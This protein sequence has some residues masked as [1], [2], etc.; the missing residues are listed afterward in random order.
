MNPQTFGRY[1][2]KEQLGR[3]GFAS[4][5][6]AYD[7]RFK[8]DV[9]VKVLPR[10]LLLDDPQFR[11][12]FEREAETIAALE[13]PAI[14][15]V[16]DF[17]EENGQPYLVM[18]LMA[19]G[20]LA[21]RITQGPLPTAEAAHILRRIGSAL[22]R[23]HERGVIHRD[24]KPGNIL[25]DQYGEAFLAD[26]GIVRL[27][28]AGGT[29][30]ATGG[31]VGTPA[32]MSPEQIR[33]SQLD[34]R[35]DIYALGIIVFE[36]LTG[37]KP[38]DADTPAMM[39]VKQIT[40]P[41]PRVLSVNPDLPPGCEYVITR[42][43]AKEAADRFDKAGEMADT[44]ASALQ[45]QTFDLPPTQAA[46]TQVTAPTQVVAPL[47]VVDPTVV[48]PTPPPP[49]PT[50]TTAHRPPLWVW[51]IAAAALI[52]VCACGLLALI[53]TR[54]APVLPGGQTTA[55]AAETTTA[56]DTAVS[57]PIT[58]DNITQM[59]PLQRL[60]RGTLYAA[61]L[62][63]D[64]NRLALGSSVGVWIYDAHSLEP[65]QLLEGH[66]DRVTAV[67][68]SPDGRQVASASW[69]STIRL[70]DIDSGEQVRMIQGND[71]FIALDWSP[72][73]SLLA[74]TTWGSPV[75]LYDPASTQKMGELLGNEGSVTRLAWSPDGAQLAAAD[76]G[77]NATVRLWDVTARVETAP[78]LTGHT[79]E[80]ANL[81][82]ASDSARLISS[83]FDGTAR[84]WSVDGSE[85]FVLQGHEY[86]VYDAAWSP[87]ETQILTTGGDNSVR[88]WDAA[89]GGQIRALPSPLSPAIRLIWL[90]ATNQIITFLADGTIWQ[91]DAATDAVVKENY[92]HTAGVW[93]VAWS[94]DGQLLASGG[95]DG[96]VRLWQPATG[97]QLAM[98]DA[99]DYGVSAIAFSADGALLASA[100]GDGFLR[101]WEV[102]QELEIKEWADPDYGGFSALAFAPHAPWL[103]A[104]DWD[105][106]VWLLDAADLTVLADWQ[107]FAEAPV[108]DV[109]WSPDGAM[110][111]I[112]GRDTAVPLWT[113]TDNTPTLFTEL[114]GHG[115]IVTDVTWSPDGAQAATSSQ[116]G[117]VRVWQV[118]ESQEVWQQDL[119]DLAMSAAW[120]SAG[121]PLAAARYDG[122]LFLVD[123]VNG[124]ELRQLSGHVGSV[125]SMVWSPDGAWLA[126][127]SSDGTVIVWGVGP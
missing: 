108:T 68:W 2:I 9:A 41:M 16:Y 71:Q 125:E 120:S 93:R 6:R 61:I 113:I 48:V 110:L 88:L 99:H 19:G 1:E 17:G 37:K 3:G 25:F 105:G 4:V 35:T 13:H 100:G 85:Q 54:F 77:E 115:D 11:T 81:T 66:T 69:D 83:S 38:Y 14:V 5:F 52:L 20:S 50:P 8:R 15:P 103:A 31:M 58:P 84:V 107:V 10:E 67:A 121:F 55:P 22:D 60:G 78:P 117:R 79:D 123:P 126:S 65:M 94:P 124:R 75:M 109:V 92:D 40:E 43:T 98:L 53:R 102:A 74:A 73:G 44:L 33:G 112:S 114:T 72:D 116:D 7:P 101:V 45:G 64:G 30:T 39:L 23:A 91:V 62:S 70:W 47:P 76:N 90:A 46:A 27:T 122:T 24:L 21:E 89:A 127:G 57:S 28:Q 18:R 56:I 80:I 95:D 106:H 87:D 118:V 59:A 34:G 96:L 63:R 42:A 104:A 29:L 36:M 82:W 26:F 51:L 119:H 49:P 97:E 32:Y 111:A 86:G 12:R